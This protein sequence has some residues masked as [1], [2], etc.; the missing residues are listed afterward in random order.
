MCENMLHAVFPHPTAPRGAADGAGDVTNVGGAEGR[1]M[2]D[3]WPT[4]VY[5]RRVST[6]DYN[7]LLERTV[8]LGQGGGLWWV[9]L[10]HRGWLPGNLPETFVSRKIRKGCQSVACSNKARVS[11]SQGVREWSGGK[12]GGK[13]QASCLCQY[14]AHVRYPKD[15]VLPLMS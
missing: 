2:K 10:G 3:K 12:L 13:G 15:V 7:S 1:R 14:E 5:G 4:D 9:G 11:C 6:T 8:L